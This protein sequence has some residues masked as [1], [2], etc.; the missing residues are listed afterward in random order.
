[1]EQTRSTVSLDVK[2]LK[3]KLQFQ[4]INLKN[5]IVEFRLK[6]TAH[7]EFSIDG[8][9]EARNSIGQKSV[10]TL[11]SRTLNKTLITPTD[12]IVMLNPDSVSNFF[13]KF[14]KFPDSIAVFTGG[15]INPNYKTVNID[16]SDKVTGTSRIEFPL[17]FGIQGGEITDSVEIDLSNDD[18]DQIKDLNSVDASLNISNGIPAQVSFIGRVYDEFNNFLMYFPSRNN[19]PDTIK[20]S[21]AST[22][23]QG[24]VVTSNVQTVTVKLTYGDPAKLAKGKYMR[25]NLKFSTSGSGN[26]PVK[27][28]TDNTINISAPG[29]VN[30]R[31]N[32]GGIK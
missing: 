1:L 32:N 9:M 21:G 15:V 8:R 26:S 13:K 3:N 25:V 30:Y 6:P 12:T 24:N 22:D 2:D 27:F 16:N 17:D 20:V 5:P 18:R 23:S 4:Q 19:V 31:V 29:S 7:V 11:S 10:M 14:S 28:K